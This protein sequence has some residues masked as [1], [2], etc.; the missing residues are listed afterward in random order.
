VWRLLEYQ[1]YRDAAEFLADQ[2][3]EGR[4]V[5]RRPSRAD[6]YRDE[7]PEP[8]LLPVDLFQLLDAFQKLMAERPPEAVHEVTR[9]EM[10]LRE[11]I[12]HIADF[13]RER[14][15]VTLLE[16]LY[17]H[18]SSPTRA[19]VVVTFLALLEMARFRLVK[20]LQTRL[21]SRDLIIERAVIDYDEVAQ[22]LEGIDEL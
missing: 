8:D 9:E 21:S 17:V 5:F 14:P 12:G 22:R 18:G 7:S 16:L 4:D 19:Q 2:D 3:R 11:T 6:L 15:R 1:R 10:S 13:L 20:L